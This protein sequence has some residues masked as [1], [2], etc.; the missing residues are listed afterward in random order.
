MFC[1]SLHEMAKCDFRTPDEGVF[2]YPGGSSFV[3]TFLT[4]TDCHML[5]II[6]RGLMER[7]D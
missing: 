4:P 7:L 5:G 1:D 2:V 3:A 6:D